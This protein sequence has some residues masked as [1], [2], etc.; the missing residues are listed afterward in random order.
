MYQGLTKLQEVHTDVL[1]YWLQHFK[2]QPLTVNQKGAMI[3]APHQDDETLG[4]G[5]LIALKRQL[6]ASVSVVFLTDGRKAV[7]NHHQR[8][9]ALLQLRQQEAIVALSYL[10]VNS[11]HVH[12][13]A[14][15]DGTL[16]QLSQ[17]Q[18]QHLVEHLVQ[19]L[20]QNQPDEIYIPHRADGHPDHDAT[21]ALV[22]DALEQ[23]P[24]QIELLEY[25]IWLFWKAPLFLR[26][27]PHQLKNAYCVDIR[28]VMAQKQQALEAYQSQISILPRGFLKRFY[29]PIEF[30]FKLD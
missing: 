22:C 20:K 21:Y 5:G 3:I 6:H 29:Y 7:M 1:V 15:P 18:K 27:K 13:L 8:A 28:A 23:I 24:F 12:F 25:P 26:L 19:L 30:F 4:C 14:Q 11:S 9:E 2:G 17:A 10:G 16:K